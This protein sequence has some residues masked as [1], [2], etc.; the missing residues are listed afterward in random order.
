MAVQGQAPVGSRDQATVV[1]VP[2]QRGTAA[3]PPVSSARRSWIFALIVVALLG[4]MAFVMVTVA[5]GQSATPDEPVYVATAVVYRQ[6]HSLRYNPEH[7]PLGKQIMSLGLA[8]GDVRLDKNVKA[9]QWQLGGRVLYANGNDADTVLFLAR[10]AMIALTLLFGL[11]VFLFARD[12]VGPLGGVLALTLYAF[13]PDVI[14]HGSLATLDV[15]TAG[16]LLTALWLLWRARERPLLYLPLAGLATGAALATKMTALV[17]LPVLAGLAVL[18]WWRAHPDRTRVVRL[19][20]GVAGAAGML[21]IAVAVVWVSYLAVDT[22][23][24]WTPDPAVPVPDIGGL[25]GAIID[26]LPFPRV[27]RDGM[28]IQFG[29]ENTSFD[30]Y[31]FGEHYLGSK[32]YYLPVALLIKEPL[33][34][35]A[36]W[37]AGAAVMLSVRQL[38]PAAAYVLVP[39]GMLLAVAMT[40]SRDWGVRYAIFIPIF[41]AVAAAAVLAARPRWGRF[42]AAALV[43]FVA[44]S[45]LR[46]FPHYLPYSNEALGGPALTSQR[47]H[48]SN[49]DWGQGLKETAGWLRQHYPGQKVWLVYHGGGQAAYYGIDAANPTSVPLDQV[50]GLVVISNSWIAIE[51]PGVPELVASSRK[52][53]EVGH[54]MSVFQR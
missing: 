9:T 22:H 12:L 4:Q 27:F 30:G 21:L 50:R 32:W 5:R 42:A 38:R 13:S 28:R 18:S 11:V 39:V 35:M 24:R 53:A 34:A 7:P 8:A 23:L 48:D 2:R 16:F 25:K 26:W 15:P 20:Y 47:L 1:R 19:A 43:A 40:G 54:T 44:V 52:I 3:W 33:G 45:S 49:A 29:F 37:L 41:L 17:A 36:L 14:A 31:L 6:Q 46:T 10:A 51:E